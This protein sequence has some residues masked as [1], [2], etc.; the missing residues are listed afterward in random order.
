VTFPGESTPTDAYV[1]AIAGTN[2]NSVQGWIVQD[3]YVASATDLLAWIQ[4]GLDTTPTRAYWPA[5]PNTYISL[6]TA[7]G[8]HTLLNN[9]PESPAIGTGTLS[10]FLA[11]LPKTA[12][13]IF[14][15]HSLGGALSPALAVTLLKS[16]LVPN[17]SSS[18]VLT[19][20][21]AG[22]AIGNPTF[23]STYESLF[24]PS[25]SG[26][27]Y[28][29]WNTVLW[30]TIDIVPQA[31]SLNTSSPRNVYNIPT[32]YGPK[33]SDLLGDLD[34]Y[35]DVAAALAAASL[36]RYTPLQGTSFSET[37]PTDPLSTVAE[38]LAEA[39]VQHVQKYINYVGL[40]LDAAQPEEARS[41]G[42]QISE[43]LSTKTLLEEYQ[44][45]PVMKKIVEKPGV[46]H[47]IEA[48]DEVEHQE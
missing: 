34:G 48:E 19:Y 14:T 16:T 42:E 1:V 11:T 28:Q 15:G 4:A 31:W 38:F 24:P 30:N 41:R 22:P 36:V 45:Y 23:A 13:F 27:G 26:Q 17:L 32:F 47:Q 5:P 40:P 8:L 20:P 9:A 7:I 3:G 35:V 18:N 2:P 12:R 46:A 10:T 44:S 39:V 25:A 43:G 21:T 37:T 29:T 6:G 33:T